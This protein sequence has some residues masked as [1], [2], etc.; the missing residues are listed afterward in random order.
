MRGTKTFIASLLFTAA[1]ISFAATPDYFPLQTGNSWVCRNSGRLGAGN[2]QTIDIQGTQRFNNRDYFRVSLFGRIAYLRSTD[3]G[4][5]VYNTADGQERT[6]IQ[7]DAAQGQGFPVDIEPCTRAARI[8]SKSAKVK[9]SAGEWDN[10][11][12]FSFETSC[13]DAGVTSLFFVPGLG[14][15]VYETTSIAGPVRWEL[16]Y[17]RVGSTAAEAPQVA[18]TVALDA[19]VYKSGE[20]VDM[21]VRLTLRNTHAQPVTL[22][23]SSSQRYDMRVWNDK[24]QVVYT[25]S[26]DKLF[27]QVLGSEVVGPGERTFAFTANIPNLP[28]GRYVAESWLSTFNREYV[29]VVGFEVT[30]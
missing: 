17:S 23:F 3:T 24:G 16:I 6:W 13:A 14:P 26:A 20:S 30:R 4:I 28:V 25:W 22:S 2:P 19:P 15:V 21:L 18:F 9:T 12:Q 5:N 8:E 29:G 11:I 1:S 7:F 27:A 10:A